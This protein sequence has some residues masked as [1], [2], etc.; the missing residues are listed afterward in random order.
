M[1]KNLK[2]VQSAQC[3]SLNMLSNKSLFHSL[4]IMAMNNV[5]QLQVLQQERGT[6]MW[7][8]N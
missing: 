8:K 5:K 2:T 4:T 3:S 7:N 1:C 6:K